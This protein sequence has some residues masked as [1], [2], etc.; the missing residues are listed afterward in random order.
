MY[1]IKQ[2][3]KSMYDA[4]KGICDKVYIQDRPQSIDTKI[5]SY[6]LLEVSSSIRNE[7]SNSD[8]EYNMF[9]T[10]VRFVLFVR[11]KMS[12]KNFNSIDI[13]TID[14]KLSQLNKL[15]PISDEFVLITKPYIL[16]SGNDG[17]DFHYVAVN[18]ELRTK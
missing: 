2:I 3:Y 18:A 14:K 6:I 4:V 13:N 11:N 5:N 12:A 17:S 8:G 16:M 15:F 1:S 10:I 9:T 7:E